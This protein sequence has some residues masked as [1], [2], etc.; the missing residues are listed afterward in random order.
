MGNKHSQRT[1][2]P[3]SDGNNDDRA[4]D[5]TAALHAA[6]QNPLRS[7]SRLRDDELS[8]VL[9]FL[10]LRDLSRLVRC[11]H[12][13]NGVARKERSRE[14]CLEGGSNI[15]PVASSALS[16]HVTAL[17][18]GRR[19]GADAPLTR[20]ALQQLRGSPKLTELQITLR[21]DYDVGHFMQGLTRENAAAALRAVLP[22]QLRSFLVIAGSRHSQLDVQTAALA[23]SFWAALG[24]MAQLTELHVEQHSERMHVRPDLAGLP[25]LRQLTLGPAGQ[26]GEYVAELNQLS[27]LQD[28]SLLDRFPDR[29]RLLCRPPCALQIQRLTFASSELELDEATMRVLLHLPKLTALDSWCVSPDAWSLLP[30]LPRL[31]RL[32]L[33][34]SGMLAPDR[35]STMCA[36]LSRCPKLVDLHFAGDIVSADGEPLVAEQEQAAWAT[37]LSSVPNL[38]RLCVGGDISPFLVVLPLHLPHLEELALSS[39]EHGFHGLAS[40]QSKFIDGGCIVQ[41]SADARFPSTPGLRLRKEEADRSVRARA[42]EGSDAPPAHGEGRRIKETMLSLRCMRAH[43]PPSLSVRFPSAILVTPSPV[44]NFVSVSLSLSHPCS[45][46]IDAPSPMEAALGKMKASSLNIP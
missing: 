2:T 45:A 27:Q 6:A 39:C 41:A 11:S 18:L 46:Q 42:D 36:A 5:S 30:Q 38:R 33:W 4:G 35:M 12:R 17:H 7:L 15:A 9:V 21:N 44:G 3:R 28:L 22:T 14:L 34:P 8:C 20:G 1:D 25:H 43:E 29:I 40:V 13:F 26:M 37:L 19:R 16:H 23:S 32:R 10:P 31:R 24:D